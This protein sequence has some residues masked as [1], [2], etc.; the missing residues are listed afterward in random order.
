MH[1][2]GRPVNRPWVAAMNAAD[3]SCRVS[4]SSMRELRKDSTTSRFSSPGTPKT[5]STPSFSSAATSRSDPLVIGCLLTVGCG[6]TAYCLRK[7]L[8][9]GSA[10]EV[11]RADVVLIQH[12]V[13]AAAQTA[14]QIGAPDMVQHQPC[15]QQQGGGICKGLAGDVRR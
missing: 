13:D 7:L 6:A 12:V 5:Y 4:T 14:G 10:P 1:T 2:P 3:C 15:C 8:R 9:G 11:A